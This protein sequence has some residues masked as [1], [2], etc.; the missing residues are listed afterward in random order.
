VQKEEDK[1]EDQEALLVEIEID[2]RDVQEKEEVMEETSNVRD[3]DFYGALESQP[4]QIEEHDDSLIEHFSNR[5]N[6]SEESKRQPL[7]KED[8]DKLLPNYDSQLENIM[9][10]FLKTNQ[11]C[12]GK[13]EAQCKNL[14][15][16]AYDGERQLVEMEMLQHAAVQKEENFL[17]DKNN[18]M[19]EPSKVRNVDLYG[20]LESQ[21]M[22]IEEKDLLQKEYF[23]NKAGAKSEIDKVIDMICALLA[24]V[25]LKMIWKQH[26]L[27]LKLIV[28]IPNKRNKKDDIFFL[29]YKTP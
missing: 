3:E 27:F 7:M 19:K 13:F 28:V 24:T 12:F 23:S 14:V 4:K 5:A 2:R 21:P 26:P 6:A 9:D 25:K 22:T 1:E 10:K 17:E 8:Q 20:T 11:A 29:S 18:G 15:E 16:N